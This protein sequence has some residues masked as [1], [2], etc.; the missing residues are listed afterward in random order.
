MFHFADINKFASVQTSIPANTDIVVDNFTIADTVST[1][2]QA[3]VNPNLKVPVVKNQTMFDIAC[4]YYGDISYAIKLM[5]DNKLKNIGCIIHG[6]DL[7]V[8]SVGLLNQN[9]VYFNQV[10]SVLTTEPPGK[11][12]NISWNISW[13]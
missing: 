6:L 9:V 3:V 13:D 2:V 11:S 12:F 10:K 4:R 5:L 7:N 1:F 8:N